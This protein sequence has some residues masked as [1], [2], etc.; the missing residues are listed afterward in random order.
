MNRWNIPGWLE[1]E[2]VGR[3]RRCVYCG[4]SFE[5]D[6][7]SR[8]DA[9]S[10]EHIVNDATIITRENIVRCCGCNASK[11]TKSLADW[12]GTKYCKERGMA[13]TLSGA[14]SSLGAKVVAQ[15]TMAHNKTLHQT[16][17]ALQVKAG[18]SL[19]KGGSDDYRGDEP[20][21]T[22]FAPQFLV[23]GLRPLDCVLPKGGSRL[24][25]RGTAST[26][27]A[28]WTGFS[29]RSSMRC[30][31][32]SS[33]RTAPSARVRRRIFRRALTPWFRAVLRSG[34]GPLHEAV[35]TRH[36]RGERRC[37]HP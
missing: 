20:R 36:A 31:V 3:D 4:V 37:R 23:D 5:G 29:A 19:T 25:N 1:L 35:A 14:N 26:P 24:A 15:M 8:R 11:G 18:V 30:S 28:I 34:P 12:L 21:V 17:R 13:E 33:S 7:P 9:P 16:R 27:S 10:W 2:A 32:T 22:S 6:R